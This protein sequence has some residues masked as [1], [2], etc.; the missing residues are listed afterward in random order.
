MQGVI[1][2][3]LGRTL[4]PHL[5]AEIH[6]LKLLIRSWPAANGHFN[7]RKLLPAFA[8]VRSFSWNLTSALAERADIGQTP[9]VHV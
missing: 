4:C 6:H 5:V 8:D 1:D 2:L 9:A 7:L 3:I